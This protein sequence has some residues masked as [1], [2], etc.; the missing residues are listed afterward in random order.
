[1]LRQI[2][3][4][5]RNL[6][7]L[8]AFSQLFSN[9]LRQINVY[10]INNTCCNNI[11]LSVQCY[12]NIFLLSNFS[13]KIVHIYRVSKRKKCDVN[14]WRKIFHHYSQYRYKKL[15]IIKSF[16]SSYYLWSVSL[17]SDSLRLNS[18]NSDDVICESRK[19]WTW[20]CSFAS[21][22]IKPEALAICGQFLLNQVVNTLVYIRRSRH[23]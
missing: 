17:E 10:W 13:N 1:M 16:Y 14:M 11:L 4:V 22:R 2:S 3:F 23:W 7:L 21:A 20:A 15:F 8:E 12:R 6:L 19:E 5:K 18:S 9:Y